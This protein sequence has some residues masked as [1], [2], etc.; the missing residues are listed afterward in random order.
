MAVLQ[1]LS[2]SNADGRG[3]AGLAGTWAPVWG[4]AFVLCLQNGR[5]SLWNLW[6]FY[7]SLIHNSLFSQSPSTHCSQ[8]SVRL[9]A[10]PSVTEKHRDSH[11][12]RWVKQYCHTFSFAILVCSNAILVLSEANT[13]GWVIKFPNHTFQSLGFLFLKNQTLTSDCTTSGMWLKQ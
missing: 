9:P 2:C 1:Q 4:G 11:P 13:K 10:L 8:V 3:G 5:F 6:W 7:K 12:C